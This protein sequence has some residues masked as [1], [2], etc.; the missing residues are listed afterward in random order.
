MKKPEELNRKHSSGSKEHT[1]RIL[2]P[3]KRRCHAVSTGES[4]EKKLCNYY[5]MYAQFN[6]KL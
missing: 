1:C 5:D 2:A 6:S 3:V 4:A